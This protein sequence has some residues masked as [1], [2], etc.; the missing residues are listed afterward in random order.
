MSDKIFMKVSLVGAVLLL[1]S[2]KELCGERQKGRYESTHM[3][4]ITVELQW[5]EH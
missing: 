4:T 5:L 2:L 3:Y 1:R